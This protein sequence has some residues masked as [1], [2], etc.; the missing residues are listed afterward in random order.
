MSAN[1]VPESLGV[2]NT[3]YKGL[4]TEEEKMKYL[5]ENAYILSK[6]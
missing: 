4:L 6:D 5:I 2:I 3:F 1:N